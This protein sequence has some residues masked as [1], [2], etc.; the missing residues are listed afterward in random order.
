[1]SVDLVDPAPRSSLRRTRPSRYQ[2]NEAKAHS[3]ND[4]GTPKARLP[5]R[6]TSSSTPKSC[7]GTM[8]FDPVPKLYRTSAVSFPTL[9]PRA[10]EFNSADSVSR[11]IALPRKS[12][13]SSKWR[14]MITCE[15]PTIQTE[16]CAV[17]A[18]G[19]VFSRPRHAGCRIR[20]HSMPWS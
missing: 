8:I 20:A 2:A 10:D 18:V 11:S 13:Y 7:I 12:D 5:N 4:P 6:N 19:I 15:W 14:P 16:R 17:S 9:H 1:V 3:E